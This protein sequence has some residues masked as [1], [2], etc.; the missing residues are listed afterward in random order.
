MGDNVELL[1]QISELAEKHLPKVTAGA[2][3][4]RLLLVETLEEKVKSLEERILKHLEKNKKQTK[5]LVN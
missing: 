4:E 1:K 2:L 5:N 3:Q